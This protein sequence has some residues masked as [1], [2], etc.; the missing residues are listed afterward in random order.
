MTYH[1]GFALDSDHQQQLDTLIEAHARGVY[2]SP[3]ELGRLSIMG[4]DGVVKVLALD[5]IDILK[6]TGDNGQVL[7]WVA[8]V[9]TST[10]HMMLKQLLGKVSK[11][12]QDKLSAYMLRRRV[13]TPNGRRFG[14]SLS[15]SDGERF[16]RVMAMAAGADVQQARAEL[17]DVMIRFIDLTTDN[18]YDEFTDCLDLG[19]IGRK[20]V[21]VSRSTIHKAGHSTVKKLFE[22]LTDE[23]IQAISKHFQ[24]MF[25]KL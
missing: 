22:K 5:V 13:D 16:M 23:Q 20:V 18:C 2:S 4:V 14:Y 19:M 9:V 3:E 15:D 11:Q 21:S 10:M 17:V 24:T 8:K 25:F 12:E 1:F 6:A 7:D